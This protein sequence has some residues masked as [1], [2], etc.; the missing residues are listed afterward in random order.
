MTT[1]QIHAGVVPGFSVKNQ[2]AANWTI[3]AYPWAAATVR[4]HV[5]GRLTAW[6]YLPDPV[7]VEA[8]VTALVAAALPDGGRRLSLHLA[9]SGPTACI[10]VLSHGHN[11]HDTGQLPDVA[12]L[13]TVTTCGSETGPEGRRLWAVIALDRRPV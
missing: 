2:R 11:G 10:A 13:D 7:N 5:V 12:A 4:G 8:V 1:P 3:T 9:A 6:R